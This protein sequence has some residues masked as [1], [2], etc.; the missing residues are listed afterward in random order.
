MYFYQAM[1]NLLCWHITVYIWWQCTWIAQCHSWSHNN[2]DLITIITTTNRSQSTLRN[3]KTTR[4]CIPSPFSFN[5]TL[6][7]FWNNFLKIIFSSL[8]VL[9]QFLKNYHILPVVRRKKI[10]AWHFTNPLI[11]WQSTF[12]NNYHSTIKQYRE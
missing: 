12:K 3:W 1:Y 5:L 8:Q 2:Q 11:S 4:L 9:V 10:Y 6:K 7:R